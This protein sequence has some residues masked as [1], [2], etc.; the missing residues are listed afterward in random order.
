[1]S[2]VKSKEEFEEMKKD[3]IQKTNNFLKDY[4]EFSRYVSS[5]FWR[6]SIYSEIEKFR[7]QIKDY[8][9]ITMKELEHEWIRNSVLTDEEKEIWNASKK[10]NV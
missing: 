10:Y 7:D 9:P 4:Y 6:S 1:M 5:N 2:I 3:M 8:T